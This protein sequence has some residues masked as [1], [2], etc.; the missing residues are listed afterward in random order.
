MGQFGN[1]F[2]DNKTFATSED[3][4]QPAHLHERGRYNLTVLYDGK[5]NK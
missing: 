3:S 4:D 5:I 2:W 1:D